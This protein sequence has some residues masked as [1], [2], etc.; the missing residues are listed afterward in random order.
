MARSDPGSSP[1]LLSQL[2]QIT[3]EDVRIEYHAETGKVRFLAIDPNYS[4]YQKNTPLSQASVQETAL[5]FLSTYGEL[6]GLQDAGRELAIMKRKTDSDGREFIRYQQIYRDVPVLGGEL[7]VTGKYN[8][9]T[10]V[11]GEI[12]PDLELDVQPRL[13]SEDARQTALVSMAKYY[14]VDLENLIASEPELW[15]YNPA[16]VGGPGPRLTSLVWKV[17][18]ETL[19]LLPIREFILIDAHTGALLLRFNQ[20]DGLLNRST[21]DA[22]NGF[23][24]PGTLVCNESNPNCSGGDAHATSAHNHARDTYNFFF[25]VHG[26]DSID[27]LGMTITSTVHYGDN[28]RNA[29]WNGKQMVFGDGYGFALADDVVAHELVHGITQHESNLYY[30]YQSGA[31]NEAFSDIWGEFIDLTNNSGN[32]DPGVKWLIG[33]DIDGLGA[34]RSMKNPPV[35]GDPDRMTSSLYDCDFEQKDNGGVHSNSGVGNK[36]AYLMAEGDTFN[37]YTVESIGITKTA[38]IWYQAATKLLT[39]GSDY[40]DLYLALQQACTYLQG[41]SGITSSDCQQ[42]KNALDAV[43]MYRQ[44]TACSAPEAPIC[45]FQSAPKS[46]FFDNLENSKSGIWSSGSVIPL[47][48]N[49]WYYP[50]PKS[51]TYTSSGI[52][53][54]YGENGNTVGDYFMAMSQPVALPSGNNVYLHF[55]HAYGFEDGPKGVQGGNEGYD[56]GVLEYRTGSGPWIDAGSLFTHNGYTGNISLRFD[57]PLKGRPAFIRKSNGYISSRVDLSGMA[58]EQIQIR[59][60][61]ATDSVGGDKGWFI[62]DIFIYSC[63]NE[64]AVNRV[65]LPYAA[66]GLHGNQAEAI[67]ASKADSYIMEGYPNLNNGTEE[68]LWVGYDDYLDP[69]GKILHGLLQ[70][71]LASLPEDT[72]VTQAELRIYMMSSYDY[73]DTART[74]TAYRATAGWNEAT[75]IW[76]NR[77]GVAENYGSVLIVSKA[78]GWYSLDVTGLVRAWVQGSFPNYG[79]V[80][81]GPEQPGLDSAW[82]G[83]STREYAYPPQLIVHYTS[84]EPAT[85]GGAVTTIETGSHTGS[86]GMGE[87]IC[88]P[89][90]ETNREWCF[91]P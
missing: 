35:F 7:I 71:D 48:I 84:L 78:W 29:F 62:D 4:L 21:H 72:V 8:S 75:V 85:P 44:P 38:K 60:R 19:E 5:Q 26:R 25:N 17:E 68:D 30:Y 40:Q 24:L 45:S 55:N 15:I 22:E 58:G 31:I 41:T 50:Q 13:F 10:S 9:I 54:L 67:F 69:E 65:Y 3:S 63:E 70:F 42:V 80:L 16:L 47:G 64:V 39:S 6:F 90:G 14:E 91:T 11:N 27:G 89:M 88:M 61:M 34:I 46:I 79:I 56:G 33:E 52:Y 43:E 51:Q 2:N 81:R 23:S 1:D 57:N 73:P 59:F 49:K 18:V 20:I 28:Y 82:R 37:G 87:T 83:F 36:A 32:D 66:T 76:N 77:P 12:L 53:N 74:I 86:E